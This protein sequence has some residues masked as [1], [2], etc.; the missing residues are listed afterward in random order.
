MRFGVS[1]GSFC[2]EVIVGLGFVSFCRSIVFVYFNYFG[3]GI[4][5]FELNRG[6]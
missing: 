6:F 3:C 1:G 2:V 5:V 4:C